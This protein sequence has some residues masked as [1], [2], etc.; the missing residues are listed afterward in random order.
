M[1]PIAKLGP[2]DIRPVYSSFKANGIY[3]AQSVAN[4]TPAVNMKALDAN[5]KEYYTQQEALVA[6]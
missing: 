3:R 1:L 6:N 5:Q 2:G 4:T